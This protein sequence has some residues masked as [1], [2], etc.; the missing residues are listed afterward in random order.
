VR[1]ILAGA[2]NGAKTGLSGIP[3]RFLD[4]LENIDKLREMA[5]ELAVQA[6]NAAAKLI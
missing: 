4:G 5:A 1:V 2:L 3:Q 6:T